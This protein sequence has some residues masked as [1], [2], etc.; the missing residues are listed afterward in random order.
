MDSSGLLLL[1]NDGELSNRL[2]HPRHE[3]HKT[4][5]VS[6]TGSLKDDDVRA[7]DKGLYAATPRAGRIHAKARKTAEPRVRVIKRDRDRT[8]VQ[9]ALGEGQNHQVRRMMLRLGYKVRKL[10]CVQMGPLKLRGLQPGQWR[11]LTYRELRE[12]K[13]A[14][15][16]KEI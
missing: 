13:R 8:S 14:A 6:M 16:M 11:E 9:M 7:I 4:Y 5:Q 12:L 1:T 15:G 3:I 2:T 10:R